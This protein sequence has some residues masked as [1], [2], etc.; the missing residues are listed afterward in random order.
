MSERR[1]ARRLKS[2]LRGFVY[3]DK[4]RGAMSC[5]VRDLS[6]E[7]ARIIFSET[8]TI[9]D[10]LNLHIPQKDQTLRARVSW[11]RGD[12]I[13]LKFSAAAATTAAPLPEPAELMK[14]IAQLEGEIV[15]LQ[16]MLRRMKA[17][18][19]PHHEDDIVAA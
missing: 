9:P 12:E 6:D 14:R 17:E 2:F 10:V 7:G 15:K 18:R 1:G 4:R 8:V 3:F 13:G 11:R 5:L 16:K 19:P